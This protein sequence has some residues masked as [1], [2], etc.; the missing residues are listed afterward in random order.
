MKITLI[1]GQSHKGSTYHVARILAEKI[2]G[3]ITEIV[4]PRDFDQMCVGCAQCIKKDEKLCPHYEKLA[5]ITEAI[6][7]ADLLIFESPVYVY[8]VTSAMK[9]LLEHYGWRWIMHRPEESMF[10]KQMVCIATA[11]GGG[12]KNTCQDMADRA[13]YWGVAKTYKYGI[14]VRAMKWEDVT[15]KTKDKIERDMDALASKI[16]ANQGRVKPPLKT[17]IFFPVMSMVLKKRPDSVDAKY[18][19]EKGWLDGKRPWK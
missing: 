9:A 11:A 16:K 2:D 7:A 19:K 12:Q 8:H 10:K 17:R 5:P 6:D 13:A 1:H 14:A 15:A 4:L 3:E 18:W